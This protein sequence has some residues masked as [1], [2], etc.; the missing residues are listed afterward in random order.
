MTLTPRT[1]QWRIEDTVSLN[2]ISHT[3]GHTGI[4]AAFLADILYGRFA[5]KPDIFLRLVYVNTLYDFVAEHQSLRDV[6]L[7]TRIGI[8]PRLH[9]GDAFGSLRETTICYTSTRD[10]LVHGYL[11]YLEDDVERLVCF[12]EIDVKLFG[13]NTLHIAFDK[14]FLTVQ[15]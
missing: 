9:A 1:K 11:F 14:K 6:P 3:W 15:L 10:I 8:S 4:Y 5:W 12:R 7:A 2:G 13:G